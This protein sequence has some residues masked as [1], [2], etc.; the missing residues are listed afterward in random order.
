M[1]GMPV[2]Y[3]PKVVRDLGSVGSGASVDLEF[4]NIPELPHITFCWFT[5]V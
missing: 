4:N 3:T 1:T 2:F 5:I